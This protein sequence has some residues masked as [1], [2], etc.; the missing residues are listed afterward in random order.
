ME[1]NLLIFKEG[2]WWVAQCLEYDI[3]AQATGTIR[4]VVREFQQ[5]FDGRIAACQE[6]RI[7]PFGLPKA[8]EYFWKLFKTALKL[9]FEDKSLPIFHNALRKVRPS[10]QEIRLSA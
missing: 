4:D 7:D 1:L 3:A 5:V 9:E 10:K 8:P 2:D 6:E